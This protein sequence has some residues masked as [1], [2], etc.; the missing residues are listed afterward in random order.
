MNLFQLLFIFYSLILQYSPILFDVVKKRT[1]LP[2]EPATLA[3]LSQPA[4]RLAYKEKV[5][6]CDMCYERT[7][8]QEWET[9]WLD[10]CS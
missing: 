2:T 5:H 9:H 1:I 7:W 10:V 6:G 3:E 4:M 8:D